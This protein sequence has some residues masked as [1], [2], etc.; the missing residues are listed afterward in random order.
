MQLKLLYKSILIAVVIS[1]I[2]I[3]AFSQSQTLYFMNNIN[4][5]NTLNP[6]FHADCNVFFGFPALSSLALNLGF[7]DLDYYEMLNTNIH[8]LSNHF[9]ED[10]YFANN[11]DLNIISLG[12]RNNKMFFSFDMTLKNNLNVNIPKDLVTFVSEGNGNH[13]GETFDFSNF[14]LQFDLYLEYA[15]GFSYEI[16]RKI[17]A[18]VKAKLLSGQANL[19]TSKFD[20][21]LY[22]NPNTYYIDL[23]S[24]VQV[25]ASIPANLILNSETQ[26]IED[27]EMIDEDAD[28]FL[29][30]YLLNNQNKG[31]AIDCGVLYKPI[32]KLEVSA[33]II[34]I[35]KIN[36]NSYVF[37]VF[38]NGEYTYTGIDFSPQE[39]NNDFESVDE[40]IDSLQNIFLVTA[41]YEKYKTRL[42]PKL[43]VGAKYQITNKI[44]LGLL[45]RSDIYDEKFHNYVTSSVNTEFFK[46]LSL[47]MSYTYASHLGNNLGFGAGFTAKA[48]QFY[49]IADNIV[50]WRIDQIDKFPWPYQARTFNFQFGIN[51]LFGR[52]KHEALDENTM[53]IYD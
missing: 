12:L 50:G 11:L 40:M 30:N 17:T 33:S 24:D 21:T 19:N 23:Y 2:S 51:F 15:F 41:N 8:E 46:W 20:I 25:D 32:N 18:G 27:F 39:I 26:E 42:T 22:T 35:G 6:A 16:N 44:N 4:Q 43:F 47:S 34:D 52:E 38:Q 29:S 7:Q 49:I 31:F 13:I 9:A 48:F 37:S 45:Y 10:N 28:Y 5:K 1:F 36:W 53:Y 14:K 3:S